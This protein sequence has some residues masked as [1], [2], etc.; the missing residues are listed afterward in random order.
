MSQ[1]DNF[2]WDQNLEASH[3]F[4]RLPAKAL[5]LATRSPTKTSDFHI[6]EFWVRFGVSFFPLRSQVK[7]SGSWALL[8]YL[9]FL[10]PSI[11]TSLTRVN[12][13][14]WFLFAPCRLQ[15]PGRNSLILTL[16]IPTS[17]HPS[18]QAYERVM[19]NVRKTEKKLAVSSMRMRESQT[20]YKWM[21]GS[22]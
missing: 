20:E 21:T 6:F 16:T 18:S 13:H 9:S 10:G 15:S 8:K 4:H 7:N 12:F 19:S 3:R 2:A 11:C 1:K 14:E 22:K 5:T 17:N